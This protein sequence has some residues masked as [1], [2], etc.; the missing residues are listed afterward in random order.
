MTE[1][2][3]KFKNT[4]PAQAKFF[5]TLKQRVD[6]YFKENNLSKTANAEMKLKTMV[7][8]AMYVAPYFLTLLVPMAWWEAML[9]FFV[10]GLGLAGIGMSVMHDAN[11]GA[12]SD[13]PKVNSL[14]GYT[15]N[16]VGACAFT[17]KIQH[18]IMHHTYTNVSEYD[19]DIRTHGVFRFTQKD[20]WKPFHR[21]QTLYALPLYSLMTLSWMVDKDLQQLLRYQREG[22]VAHVNG[23]IKKEVA[24]VLLTKTFY[25]IYIL[26]LPLWISPLTWWQW[27]IGLAIMHFVAGII[28]SVVFQLAHVVEETTFPQPTDDNVIENQWAIHQ[29]ETTADFARNNRLLN[30]YVGGLNFQVEHHLFP[31][32]CHIHYPAISRIVEQTAAEYGITYNSHGSFSDALRSHFAHLHSLGSSP[33]PAV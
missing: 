25:A 1:R 28:L 29:L 23:N 17:W 5:S 7:M 24:I 3:L 12:Y 6:G 13:N 10:M 15:L 32:I 2:T 31:N 16:L 33:I 21:F 9:L 30:W 22:M 20:A 14:L 4:H 19:E 26:L 8:L 18:N 11:H 27:L